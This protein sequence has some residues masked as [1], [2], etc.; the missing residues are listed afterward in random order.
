[1]ARTRYRRSSSPKDQQELVNEFNRLADYVSAQPLYLGVLSRKQELEQ[2][3]GPGSMWIRYEGMDLTEED[4]TDG[5]RIAIPELR[6]RFGDPQ[7]A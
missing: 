2:N 1:M 6:I 5:Q 3:P 4:R 7:K